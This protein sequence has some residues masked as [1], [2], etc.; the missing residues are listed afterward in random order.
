MC[1]G[2]IQ[3]SGSI[4]TKRQGVDMGSVTS[5]DKCGDSISSVGLFCRCIALHEHVT[6]FLNITSTSS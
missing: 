1:L 4:D 6:L 5:G 3:E 2:R